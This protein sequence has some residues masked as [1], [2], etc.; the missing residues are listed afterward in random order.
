MSL[1]D[2]ATTAPDPP[3]DDV[4]EPDEMWSFVGHKGN[5]WWLWLALCRRTRRIIGYWLGGRDEW[6]ARQFWQHLPLAWR[7]LP[8]Y[9]DR[10]KAYPKVIPA[11]QHRPSSKREGQTNHI[12]RCNCTLRQRLARFTRKT[13]SFSKSEQ[14]HEL[15]VKLFIHDY[16]LSRN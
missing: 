1:P 9:T 5:V 14:M 12:E 8:A 11:D 13:L 7:A 6:A 4:L 3:P 10:W 2:V 15:A 16:N